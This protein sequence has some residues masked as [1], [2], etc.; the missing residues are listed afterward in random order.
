MIKLQG[1]ETD[2]VNDGESALEALLCEG[3]PKIAVIDWRMP[4]IS[5]IEVIREI[6]ELREDFVY[7]ILVTGMSDPM[8]IEEGFNSGADDFLVKPAT[9]T[10]IRQRLNIAR[11]VINYDTD[12]AEARK[13]LTDYAISMKNLAEI[14]AK[15]LIHADRL[16]TLGTLSAGI[17]HEINNPATFIAGNIQLMEKF[18]QLLLE[19]VSFP[20]DK[21][22]DYILDEFPKMINDTASGVDRITRVV[23]SL[24]QYYQNDTRDQKKYFD[25]KEAIKESMDMCKF[26]LNKNVSVEVN[27]CDNPVKV[28]G[29]KNQIK[30]V[31]VNLLNNALDAVEQ[32]PE[33]Y[34]RITTEQHGDFLWL[35]LCDN[36]RGIPA[37]A[38]PQLFDPFFSTK[39][40]QNGTGLGL[41]VSKSIIENHGGELKCR[42]RDKGTCFCFSL[43]CREITEESGNIESPA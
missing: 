21:Q 2:L 12:L 39:G 25:I 30:Q 36:G 18:W 19:K 33:K 13:K 42:L 31:I 34:I 38:I 20:H 17:A 6:R 1:F 4:G 26:R 22:I 16:A 14:R 7:C 23:K 15:H 28:M 32:I 11:R 41:S 40:S 29:E 3:A 27:F 37:N 43:P 35:Y 5:G 24:K 9:L 10:S 8:D